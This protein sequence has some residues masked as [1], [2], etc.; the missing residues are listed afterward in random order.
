MG[1]SKRISTLFIII[2]IAFIAAFFVMLVY[3]YY[4]GNW[5]VGTLPF[6]NIVAIN[7]I[8]LLIPGVI[9]LIAALVFQK[10]LC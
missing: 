6:C 9:I 7:A 5:R 10:K 1:N 8:R 3:E 2:G 4:T